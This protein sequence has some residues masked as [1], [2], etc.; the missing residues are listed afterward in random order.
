[1]GNGQQKEKR[2]AGRI[3]SRGDWVAQTVAGSGRLRNTGSGSEDEARKQWAG[4]KQP[5]AS[6]QQPAVS[7]QQERMG[8]KT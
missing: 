4:E 2:F 1:V 7:G 8:E 3:G 5:A 6:S